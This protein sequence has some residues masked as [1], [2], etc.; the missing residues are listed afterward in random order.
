MK[1]APLTYRSSVKRWCCTAHRRSVKFRCHAKNILDRTQNLCKTRGFPQA[2]K[3]NA[4]LLTLLKGRY[5]AFFLSLHYVN[6][7]QV[8]A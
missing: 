8:G 6:I 5:A 2:D 3:Q 4:T 1:P 7:L